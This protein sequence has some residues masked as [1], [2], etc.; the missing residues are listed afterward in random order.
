MQCTWMD[1]LGAIG[2][3]EVWVREETRVRP[4]KR[5]AKECVVRSLGISWL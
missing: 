4:T 5:L 2:A 1:T 3:A